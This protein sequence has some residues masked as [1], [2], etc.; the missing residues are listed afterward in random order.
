[1]YEVG[2][3]LIICPNIHLGWNLPSSNLPIQPVRLP[4]QIE[5]VTCCMNVLCMSI[6]VVSGEY[7]QSL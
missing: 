3:M 4:P 1:M 2:L 5:S 6:Q 7:R